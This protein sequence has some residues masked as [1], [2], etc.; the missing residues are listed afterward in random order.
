MSEK[1]SNVIEPSALELYRLAAKDTDSRYMLT[2]ICIEPN[3]DVI[4]TDGHRMAK[5]Q[6]NNRPEQPAT[7]P[8]VLLRTV[9]AKELRA[10]AKRAKA[11]SVALWQN[12]EPSKVSAEFGGHSVCYE[13]IESNFPAYDK[14]IASD[15]DTDRK[16]TVNLN[17]L[18]DVVAMF[19]AQ[20]ARSGHDDHESFPAVNIILPEGDNDPVRFTCKVQGGTTLAIIMPMRADGGA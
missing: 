8:R 1:K 11:E 14:V 4:S 17:Y 3:G 13:A 6:P 9:D 10:T 18:A 19:K 15:T 7:L 20:Q 12:G 2:S 5:F 16:L